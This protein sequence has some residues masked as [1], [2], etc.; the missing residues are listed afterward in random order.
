VIDVEARV[1][2]FELEGPRLT[3]TELGDGGPASRAGDGMEPIEC[4]LRLPSLFLRLT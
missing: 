2:R 3:G 4:G 1:E